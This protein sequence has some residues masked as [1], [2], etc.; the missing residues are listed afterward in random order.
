MGTPAQFQTRRQTVVAVQFDGTAE[1]AEQIN[2]WSDGVAIPFRSLIEVFT[3]DGS[4]M[5]D[6]TDWICR[7]EGG[8]WV[9]PDETFQRK[10]EAV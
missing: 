3:P 6:S 2:D 10:Y 7:D 5:A 9:C 1:C 4:Q 8:F